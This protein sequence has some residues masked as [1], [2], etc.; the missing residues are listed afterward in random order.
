[1]KKLDTVILLSPS[2]AFVALAIC[3]F[4]AS[5]QFQRLEDVRQVEELQKRYD[6]FLARAESGESKLTTERWLA[7]LRATREALESARNVD[8]RFGGLFLD[9]AGIATGGLLLQATA[10]LFVHA[11]MRKRLRV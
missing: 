7:L 8:A 2:L 6:T 5:Q 11:R 10:V 1:M 9:L 3:A 4:V